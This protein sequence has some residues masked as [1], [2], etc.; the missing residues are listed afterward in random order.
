MKRIRLNTRFI[1]EEAVPVFLTVGMIPFCM[2]AYF[3]EWVHGFIDTTLCA[4]V[5]LLCVW[6]TGYREWEEVKNKMVSKLHFGIFAFSFL[7]FISVITK[8]YAMTDA[9]SSSKLF[10]IAIAMVPYLIIGAGYNNSI[11]RAEKCEEKDREHHAAVEGYHAL[12]NV[13]IFLLVYSACFWAVYYWGSELSACFGISRFES[14]Q[15][16]MHN[17]LN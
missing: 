13:A 6:S 1:A 15:A 10:I 8:L 12:W 11:S 4:V 9:A 16:T 7:F 3:C 2:L 5:F 17:L 14:W